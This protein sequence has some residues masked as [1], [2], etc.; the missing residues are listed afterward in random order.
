LQNQDGVTSVRTERLEGLGV[1]RV[2]IDAR[3]FY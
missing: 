1:A 2:E 3:D